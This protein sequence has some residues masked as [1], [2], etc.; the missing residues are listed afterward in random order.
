V[1]RRLLLLRHGRTAW[2]DAGRAQGH[3]DIDLDATGHAQART[4]ALHLAGVDVAALWSS[5]L[6]RARQTA[7]YLAEGTGLEV[8]VDPRLREFDVGERQGL[9]LA[10]F[11]DLY[12]EE[13]SAWMRGDGLVPVKGGEVS[14]EVEAR[15]V[16][17]LRDCLASLG[18][19]E[20]GLV[21]THGAAMKVA[22]TG[23]LEWPL[24]L[25]GSLKAVGNCAWITLEEI[26]HGGR[27]RLAA[28]NQ[29]APRARSD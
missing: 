12:P 16:P 8:G 9:T 5:D 1:S 17:A 2:N 24:A 21:V 22:V 4:A 25:A 10:E 18:H 19:G 20:T 6:A 3:A 26:E 28:Y 29:K 11:A 15:I 7:A 13:Y 23:M 14:E 27:L